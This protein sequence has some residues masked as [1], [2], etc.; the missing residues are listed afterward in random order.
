MKPHDLGTKIT[1]LRKAKGLTQE[2]L[3]ELCNISVRT[4]QR[5][6]TGKV[7]PRAFTLNVIF[8]ALGEEK[9][10][11]ADSGALT[12]STA[13]AAS[14]GSATLAGSATDTLPKQKSNTKKKI[15]IFATVVL[16]VGLSIFVLLKLLKGSE[17]DGNNFGELQTRPIATIDVAIEN[18][19]QNVRV[20]KLIEMQ[21]DNIFSEQGVFENGRLRLDFPTEMLSKDVYLVLRRHTGVV[22]SDESARFAFAK[23]EGFDE[24]DNLLGR[25][26]YRSEE[27]KITTIFVY[28]D[29]DVTL[30]GRDNSEDVWNVSL[31]EGW[32][33]V[34]HEEIEDGSIIM[35]TSHPGTEMRWR[36]RRYSE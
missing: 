10:M 18:V 36:F 1:D 32:N 9:P 25:F 4:L 3:A 17:T 2:E 8:S 7:E 19:P 22:R 14:T 29:R 33:I 31:K 6:E 28:A 5:I 24:N 35:S 26:E 11:T 21:D 13:S 15:A 27:N 30:I 34:F 23:I 16:V 20:A 12:A